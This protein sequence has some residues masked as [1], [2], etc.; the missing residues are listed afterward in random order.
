MRLTFFE[1]LPI[2]RIGGE[3]PISFNHDGF[4]AFGQCCA[5]PGRFHSNALR[6]MQL[7][8]NSALEIEVRP[9]PS[10]NCMTPAWC[11]LGRCLLAH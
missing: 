6:R 9:S 8:F 1:V 3:I 7:I 4:V 11:H 5:T 2:D 10:S